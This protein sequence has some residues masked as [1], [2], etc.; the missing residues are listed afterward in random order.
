LAKPK[1]IG[2]LGYRDFHAFN[3]YLIAKQA[4]KFVVE[5]DKLVSSFQG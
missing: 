4:W 2:G 3:M 1:A 5:P